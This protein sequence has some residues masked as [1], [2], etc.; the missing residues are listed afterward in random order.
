MHQ[1]WDDGDVTL[2]RRG[3]LETDVVVGIVESA[4]A[5]RARNGC[6]G[7]SDDGQQHA[8]AGYVVVDGCTEVDAGL[9]SGHV[10]EDA[11][12]TVSANEVVK[13]PPGFSL[14]VVTTIAD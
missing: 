14:G 11:G 6:P 1:H 12:V 2:Q 9:N 10:H 4:G 7:R 8:A 3:D 5:V 13:E